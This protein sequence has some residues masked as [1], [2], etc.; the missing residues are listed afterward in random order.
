MASFI[1]YIDLDKNKN[2]YVGRLL[3]FRLIVFVRLLS[4]LFEDF[5]KQPK[6]VLKL[7]FEVMCYV[8]NYLPFDGQAIPP[9]KSY[10][11]CRGQV[12]FRGITFL[13]SYPLGDS[14]SPK[15]SSG[16]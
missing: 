14:F 2:I 7:M 10:L 1:V 5:G 9:S 3:E 8:Q 6:V 11:L 16:E 4:Y 12:I 15:L 13:Q